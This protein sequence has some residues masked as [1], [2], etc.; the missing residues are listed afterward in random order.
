V[1]IV[2]NIWQ[3]QVLN[4]LAF[5]GLIAYIQ[6]AIAI[7]LDLR[8]RTEFLAEDMR[9]TVT[10]FHR[11]D[12]TGALDISPTAFF[13]ITYPSIDLQKALNAID[14]KTSGRPLI[15]L[16]GLGR[17]KSHIM[18]AMDHAFNFPEVVEQWA[19]SWVALSEAQLL[20]DLRIHRG[21]TPITIN[22]NDH[23]YRHLWDVLF[24]H[25]P[26]GQRFFG[27]FEAMAQ[28]VPS[29][30]LIVDMLK[31]QPVALLLDELQSWFEGTRD[32]PGD[33]G[34]K[35]RS[36]AFSFLQI[37]SQIAID[38]PQLLILIVS[39]RNTSTDAYRQVHRNHPIL[40]DFLTPMARR[41]CLGPLE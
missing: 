31:E 26:C 8:L 33:T 40:I 11:E 16:G 30:E 28:D 4:F 23:G 34:P 37:L 35:Y 13:A 15:L 41:N 24:R 36:W 27:R 20:K 29:R 9:D 6:G 38:D 25:H 3:G 7:M 10:I 39:V 17:G 5:L 21:Y 1:L 14:E 22:L 19:S 12:K 18:A 2:T 32:R